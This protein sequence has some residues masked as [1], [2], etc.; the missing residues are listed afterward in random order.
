[1]TSGRGRLIHIKQMRSKG[2]ALPA[3]RKRE[4]P[5]DRIQRA[6][7]DHLRSRGYPDTVFFH[8]PNG[9]KLGGKRNSKGFPIQAAR[10]KGLGVRAGVSDLILIRA[11]KIY[12]LELKAQSNTATPAQ[13]DFLDD[14]EAAGAR[15]G[16]AT[17]LDEAI[18]I[19]ESW[20]LLR[21]KSIHNHPNFALVHHAEGTG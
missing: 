13:I 17:G 1:M 19:L 21:G 12:C 18:Q 6:V 10:L 16:I 4:H 14:V 5:E 11:G 9:M 3:N 2:P 7:C 20:G 8:V 15:T